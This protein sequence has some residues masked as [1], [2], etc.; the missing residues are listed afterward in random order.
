MAESTL[1]SNLAGVLRE[2]TGAARLAGRD[3][4][5]I[6]LLAVS[7]TRPAADVL[8]ALAAGQQ[9][10][11][12]NYVQEAVA[13]IAQVAAGDPPITPVWHFIGAIQTNKTRDIARHFQWVHTVSREKVARRL[14]DQCPE[15]GRL[16]ICLQVNVDND[17]NKA[18]VAPEAAADLLDACTGLERLDVRGLMTILDPATDPADG[19]NR[20]RTLFESLRDTAPDCWD[21]LSMGMS[22]DYQAAITAGASLV[23]VGTAIFGPRTAVGATQT[24]DRD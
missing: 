18:G 20:L 12:E 1:A 10:F 19:Y 4:S 24:E 5:Q 3:P 2:I 8:A 16:S 23:R 9:H 14:N 11:G 13:K 6:T 17:P 21:T 15:K 7:K 22:G